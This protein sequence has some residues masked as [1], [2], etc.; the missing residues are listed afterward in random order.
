ML[1]HA[2]SYLG[3]KVQM[4]SLPKMSVPVAPDAPAMKRLMLTQGELA[5]FYDGAEGI[6]YLAWIDL[7]PGQPRG[8]HYHRAKQEYVYLLAGECDL[9]V[10]T[11][12]GD[13][14]ETIRL[15]TGD[16]AFIA[17]LVVHV[18]KPVS[19]GHAVEFSPQKFDHDD[20]IRKIV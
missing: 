11:L 7:I 1:K 20:I 15:H 13:A 8:N 9:V 19:P 18:L 3:G 10:A 2:T 14:R 17:P 5:Q 4:L 16:L 6:R 12:E